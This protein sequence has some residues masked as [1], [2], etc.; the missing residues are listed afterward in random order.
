MTRQQ[1]APVGQNEVLLEERNF[2]KHFPI[3]QGIIFS[4]QVVAGQAVADFSF[5]VR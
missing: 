3:R 4:M 2:V 1:S 5:T